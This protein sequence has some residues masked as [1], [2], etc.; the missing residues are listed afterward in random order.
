LGGYGIQTAPALSRLAAGL[1]KGGPTDPDLEALDSAAEEMSPDR[2]GVGVGE[3][4]RTAAE[5]SAASGATRVT[6]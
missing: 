4:S 3:R 1:L 5:G 6:N 2:F